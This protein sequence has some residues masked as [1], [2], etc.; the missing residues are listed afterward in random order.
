MKTSIAIGLIV[1]V[2][3]SQVILV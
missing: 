2:V 3:T 1:L